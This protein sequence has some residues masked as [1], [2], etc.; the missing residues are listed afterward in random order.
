[1]TFK[2]NQRGQYPRTDNNA[3]AWLADRYDRP[4]IIKPSPQSCGPA[5]PPAEEESDRWLAQQLFD[6]YNG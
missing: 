5:Q 3:T 1:M 4:Q 2:I 6:H